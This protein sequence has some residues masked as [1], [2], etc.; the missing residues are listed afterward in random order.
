MQMDGVISYVLVYN[1]ALNSHRDHAELQRAQDDHGR[2]RRHAAVIDVELVRVL[3]P[4]AAVIVVGVLL[5]YVWDKTH[6][7]LK[8]DL[9]LTLKQRW[10]GGTYGADESA[11]RCGRRCLRITWTS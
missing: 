3:G 1:Q 11:A 6:R 8:V 2:P 9:T 10:N 5:A 4:I 7:P